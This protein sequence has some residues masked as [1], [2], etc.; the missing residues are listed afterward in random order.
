MRWVFFLPLLVL[1]ALFALSNTQEVEIRLW[2][3]DAAWAASLGIAMLLFGAAAFLIGAALVWASHVP[4]RRRARRI[5]Q[6]A[7]LLEAELA[8]LKAR[9]EQARRAADMGRA[10]EAEI[11]PARALGGGR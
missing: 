7:R 2:P 4:E 10:A 5:E 9:D 8:S 1:L 3:L 6:A 11:I